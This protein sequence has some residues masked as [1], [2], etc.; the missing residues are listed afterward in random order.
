MDVGIIGK[1]KNQNGQLLV[2]DAP[3]AVGFGVD[4]QLPSVLIVTAG[5]MDLNP[6][7][8]AYAG[9]VRIYQL[10]RIPPISQQT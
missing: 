6:V 8:F 9:H 5:A 1:M 3:E 10:P 7:S 4:S 2:A